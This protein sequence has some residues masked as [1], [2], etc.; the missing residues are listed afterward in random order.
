[1]E[2]LFLDRVRLG[3]MAAVAT[4]DELSFSYL[5]KLLDVTDGNLGA[6]LRKLED[7]GV[8]KSRKRFIGAKPRTSYCI[9]EKGR[10]A[11]THHV[12]ELTV[13]LGIKR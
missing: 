1:M 11:L 9:T 3:I 8:I 2:D 12:K 4:G 5:R 7:S 13:L 6:H 10:K